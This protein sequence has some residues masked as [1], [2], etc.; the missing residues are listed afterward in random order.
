MGPTP[1]QDYYKQIRDMLLLLR[2]FEIPNLFLRS[3]HHNPLGNLKTT[4]PPEDWRYP[5]TV[6]MYNEI[7]RNLTAELGVPFL[8]TPDIIGSMW[9]SAHDFCHYRNDE[10]SRAEALFVLGEAL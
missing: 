8:D 3:V 6:D 5:A 2:G 9:D 1:F 7:H 4:C 10:T